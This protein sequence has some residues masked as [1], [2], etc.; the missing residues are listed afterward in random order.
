[1]L[2]YPKQHAVVM[3]EPGPHAQEII[4]DPI[5]G[6]LDNLTKFGKAMKR[7]LRIKKEEPPSKED[8]TNGSNEIQNEE[9]E[10]D[11]EEKVE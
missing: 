7:M 4:M 2:I 8:S 11:I 1:M 10:D 6:Q 5:Q 3:R 9:W